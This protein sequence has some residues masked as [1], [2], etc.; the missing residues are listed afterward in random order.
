MYI[1]ILGEDFTS[2]GNKSN[3]PEMDDLSESKKF[4]FMMH[5]A[6]Q[7]QNEKTESSKVCMKFNIYNHTYL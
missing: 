2:V 1:Y 4:L 3:L 5:K 7:L 6:K